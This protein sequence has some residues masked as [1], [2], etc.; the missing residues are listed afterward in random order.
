MDHYQIV[1]GILID[2]TNESISLTQVCETYHIPQ[3]FLEQLLEYGA[4]DTMKRP[5]EEAQFNVP[6][7]KR[8]C[9]AHRLQDDLGVNIEGVVLVLELLDQVEQ[10]RQELSILQRHVTP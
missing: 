5:M 4:F 2:D 10:L 9:S 7:I 3:A 1:T 6:M 8:I